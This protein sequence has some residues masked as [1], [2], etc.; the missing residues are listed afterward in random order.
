MHDDVAAY[1]PVDKSP[2]GMQPTDVNQHMHLVRVDVDACV[3]YSNAT[4]ENSFVRAYVHIIFA[5]ALHTMRF[6]E[7][8]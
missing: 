1:R 2:I 3:L 4:V 5:S 7:D 6:K 8:I